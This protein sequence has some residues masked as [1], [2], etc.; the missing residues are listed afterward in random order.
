VED[1]LDLPTT[2]EIFS[3]YAWRAEN[4]KPVLDYDESFIHLKHICLD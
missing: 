2:I 3:L 1:I 4:F